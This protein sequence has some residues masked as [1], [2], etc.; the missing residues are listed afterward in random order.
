[1]SIAVSIKEQYFALLHV[2]TKVTPNIKLLHVYTK[3]TPNI[4]CRYLRAF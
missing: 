4:K 2:Y 1:M 3:A